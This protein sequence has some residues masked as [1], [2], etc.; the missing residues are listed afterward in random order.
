MVPEQPPPQSGNLVSNRGV[1]KST[2]QIMSFD[3]PIGLGRLGLLGK[4]NKPVYVEYTVR[5]IAE[6]KDISYEEAAQATFDNACRFFGIDGAK[7]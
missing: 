7:I 5:K 1:E 3:L 2:N 6:I 4:V